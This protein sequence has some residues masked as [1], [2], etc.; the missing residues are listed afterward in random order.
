MAAEV[1]KAEGIPAFSSWVLE[2]GVQT[3]RQPITICYVT[4]A[5]IGDMQRVVGITAR[6]QAQAQ[7]TIKGF[8]EKSKLRLK[9]KTC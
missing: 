3:S 4:T 1:N 5:G 8:L 2:Q 9:I 6:H 7:G